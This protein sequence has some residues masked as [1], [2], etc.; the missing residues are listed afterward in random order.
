MSPI[1]ARRP[2]ETGRLADAGLAANI[3]HRHAIGALLENERLL[4]LR[5]SLRLH[6]LR[7]SQPRESPRKT[8]TKNDLGFRPQS[9][10]LAYRGADCPTRFALLFQHIVFVV[11]R[12]HVAVGVGEWRL[13]VIAWTPCRRAIVAAVRRRSCGVNFSFPSAL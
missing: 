6:R 2:A 10:N 13:D 5:K 1:A 4:R 12:S 11:N 9:N 8:L 7:S 3:R